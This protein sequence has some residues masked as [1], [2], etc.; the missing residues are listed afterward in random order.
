[1]V[2]LQ[3]E[4]LKSFDRETVALVHCFFLEASFLD[5]LEFRCCHGGGFII[6]ARSLVAGLL[7]F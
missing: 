7:F 5:I 6:A 4:N 1:M 2:Y 3:D